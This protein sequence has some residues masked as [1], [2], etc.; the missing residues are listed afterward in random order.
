MKTKQF[1]SPAPF[2]VLNKNATLLHNS[3][4]VGN[5]AISSEKERNGT[6]ELLNNQWYKA[7]KSAVKQAVSPK[8]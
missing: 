1:Q 5:C 4:E 3:P 7:V 6:C 2:L 8:K